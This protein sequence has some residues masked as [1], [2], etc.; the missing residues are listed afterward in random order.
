LQRGIIDTMKRTVTYMLCLLPLLLAACH[1]SPKLP[2]PMQRAEALMQPHPD[3]AL[4]ILASMTPPPTAQRFQFEAWKVLLVQA[5]DRNYLP[6]TPYERA[7]RRSVA[8]FDSIATDATSLRAKA[9][10]YLGRIYQDKGDDVGTVR[11]F[12]T[13]EP[14]AENVKDSL[15]LYLLKGNLAQVLRV[16][17]VWSESEQMF[18][19]IANYYCSINDSLHLA[20]IYYNLALLK[21]DI[22]KFHYPIAKNYLLRSLY[23][24][25]HQ[26][27]RLLES[28]L[29][30][31][32]ASISKL[33]NKIDTAIYYAR[34]GLPLAS[35]EYDKSRFYLVIGEM[36]NQKMQSDSALFYLKKSTI[37]QNPY[38][39]SEAAEKISNIY[40]RRCNLNEALRFSEMSSLYKDK[41]SNSEHSSE[42]IISMKNMIYKYHLE[43]EKKISLNRNILLVSLVI[44]L[45]ML[46]LF[47]IYKYKKYRNRIKVEDEAK[48]SAQFLNQ[49]QS[50]II[51]EKQQE[52]EQKDSEIKRLRS[53]QSREDFKSLPAYRRLV[54]LRDSNKKEDGRQKLEAT[55]W[56]E[57]ETEV[58]S[59]IPHFAARLTKAYP[60]MTSSDIEFC[61]VSL[62]GFSFNDIPYVL[63]ISFQAL[64]KRKNAI[65]SHTGLESLAQ[66][67]EYLTHLDEAD[68][69][70]T[71]D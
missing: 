13:A 55:D 17:A 31:S 32:L 61:I 63:G 23:I 69:P 71:Q 30:S 27:N 16:N 45:I 9:H 53:Q 22:E 25:R 48:L 39:I 20:I 44:F 57:I 51:D 4:A 14:L 41:A 62:F 24:I 6:I 26:N 46:L 36:M 34:K 7:I 3:S 11:E 15:F 64:Y 52:L 29:Y 19:E 35:D 58:N 5:R 8:Y 67:E 42:V 60:K 65:L 18:K 28:D 54:A 40:R 56:E 43:Q 70:K 50:E 59:I 33:E 37:S 12:L 49:R 47:G 1:R 38:I 68:C 66:L 2:L 10:Y 21:M